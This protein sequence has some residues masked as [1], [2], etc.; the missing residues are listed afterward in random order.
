MKIL[1]F[2]ITYLFMTISIYSQNSSLGIFDKQA[3]IGNPKLKGS[4]DYNSADQS[5]TLHGAGYNIWFARDEFHYTYKE[6]EGN[7]ILT[8]HFGF[9][10]KGT[11]PHRKIGWMVRESSADDAVHMSAVIHG[12]GLTVLQWRVGK[13]QE[14]RDPED[15]IFF[16]KSGVEIIQLE[17]K[18]KLFIMRAAQAG[19]PLQE[20]GTK[21]L[22]N[23][24]DQVLAGL[25]VCSHDPEIKETGRAWNVRI[26]KPV[27]DDYNPYD[28]GFLASR[29]ETMDV[30][31]G[32]RQVIYL[33]DEGFEAPNWMPDGNKL[34]F[35]TGGS[36]YTIPVEGGVPEKFN[37]GFAD[38][39]NN[40]HGISF[41]GKMLAFSHSRQGLKG[42]GSTVYVMPLSGG[43]PILITEG[44][45][46]Y[47][48]G[49]AADNK[50]VYYVA[51]RDTNVYNV[52]KNSIK[53]G[54]EIQLTFNNSH[55]VDGP[56][57]SPDGKFVYFNGSMTGTM[58][59]WRMKPDGSN[60]E[61]ITYDQYNDWFPHVSPDGKWIVF[62]SFPY[63]INPD[64]HPAYK[65]VMLRLMPA[66]GGAPKVIA[67]LYGGQGTINVPSWSPDSRHIAFMSNPGK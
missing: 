34:L 42:G 14:M 54:A 45:P 60:K 53:G 62:I 29:L 44:T 35:N 39:L 30:F 46:S 8:A 31:T 50:S 24:P 11:N 20:V 4:S 25:F 22:E 56:E 26:D 6:L 64:N 17:R 21:E 37:T 40:D 33:S 10:G 52:Y 12:D 9:E 3:D 5:Y 55:H 1:S 47:F 15:E 27:T 36:L 38:R 18:G 67:Y 7:F 51:Q 2:L 32:M 23:M 41:D 57:E 63:T 49:W 65:R 19:E 66:S 43:T 16:A 61:Q 59:I 48:H 13:G 28:Q 58:Q